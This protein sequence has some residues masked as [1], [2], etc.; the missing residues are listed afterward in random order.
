VNNI[1]N[2]DCSSCDA[3]EDDWD[4]KDA[5]VGDDGKVEGTPVKKTPEDKLN[6][7]EESSFTIGSTYNRSTAVD[8]HSDCLYGS[9]VHFLCL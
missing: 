6:V 1:W 5:L 3:P 7:N 2:P 9:F 8:P 4:A